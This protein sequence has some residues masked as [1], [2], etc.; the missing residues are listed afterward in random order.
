MSRQFFALFALFLAF[1]ASAQ[2]QQGLTLTPEGRAKLME[3]ARLC[4]PDIERFCANVK[5]G[6]GRIYLCLIDH[7]AELQPQCRTTIEAARQP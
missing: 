3:A 5:R 6:E 2:A 1:A 4:R 7:R